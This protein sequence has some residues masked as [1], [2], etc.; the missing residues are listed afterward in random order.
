MGAGSPAPSKAGCGTQGRT[1]PGVVLYAPNGTARRPKK[2]A[3]IPVAFLPA[4]GERTWL[5]VCRYGWA[6]AAPYKRTASLKLTQ[7]ASPRDR[8]CVGA[9]QRFGA[10]QSPL[11]ETLHTPE[12]TM[13]NERTHTPCL[14]VTLSTRRAPKLLAGFRKLRSANMQAGNCTNS[15]FAARQPPNKTQRT[16]L[17]LPANTPV[18]GVLQQPHVSFAKFAG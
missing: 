17:L 12:R 9:G 7:K 5:A 16:H 4:L 10:V 3:P 8:S 18:T 6:L 11:G 15:N 14:F 1:P 13:C 2:R